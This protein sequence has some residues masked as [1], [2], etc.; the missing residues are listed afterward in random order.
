MDT[1][2]NDG[3]TKQ[4]VDA[5]IGRA[6]SELD[7][8]L[9]RG[10]PPTPTEVAEAAEAWKAFKT[11]TVDW[12]AFK[13]AR[14]AYK[15]DKGPTSEEVDAALRDD[16]LPQEVAASFGR[17]I[18]DFSDSFQKIGERLQRGEV[19]TP[20][21]RATVSTVYKAF[22]A[23]DSP[24]APGV[25]ETIAIV[26]HLRWGYARYGLMWWIIAAGILFLEPRAAA[27]GETFV[28]ICSWAAWGAGVWGT[29][30][31]GMALFLS[32]KRLLKSF[33]QQTRS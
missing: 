16:A 21:E 13:D 33:K 12:K 9:Q 29:G 8:R 25:V 18:C 19:L 23:G 1:D 11:G 5:A 4:E 3:P 14:K 17:A 10:D 30:A 6:M 31:V 15:E 24:A 2:D 20:E 22:I 27:L 7:D 28:W 32:D 26:R